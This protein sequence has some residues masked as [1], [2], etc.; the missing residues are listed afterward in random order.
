M[1]YGDGTRVCAIGA[2]EVWVVDFFED[3][4]L[5]ADVYQLRDVNAPPLR[6]PDAL[7]MAFGRL[8]RAWSEAAADLGIRFVESF[9]LER[10][11][12][13]TVQCAGHLP[14]G[15][16]ASAKP[17][18]TRNSIVPNSQAQFIAAVRDSGRVINDAELG[19]NLDARFGSLHCLSHGQ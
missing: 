14:D 16:I 10:P 8:R 9:S 17:G 3:G 15:A 18:T 19:R 12:G 11:D 13:G 6:T 2:D 1:P 7:E 4:T 5:E